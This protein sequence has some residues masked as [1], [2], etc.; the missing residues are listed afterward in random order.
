MYEL[1]EELLRIL[2][3]VKIRSEAIPTYAQVLIALF[4]RPSYRGNYSVCEGNPRH[5]KY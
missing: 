2:A 3:V 5:E 1:L 4:G